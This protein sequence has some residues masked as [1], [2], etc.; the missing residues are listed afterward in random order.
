[1]KALFVILP[2]LVVAIWSYYLIYIISTI[3][4]IC[5]GKYSTKSKAPRLAATAGGLSHGFR[6]DHL[7]QMMNED[8]MRA[9]NQAHDDAVRMSHIA[10][11]D[12]MHAH[13]MGMHMHETAHFDSMHMHDAGMHMHD[14]GMH[15]HNMF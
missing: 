11:N 4:S 3:V 7:Q 9:H 1:M 14:M 6:S 5:K 13:D 10:H 2:I 15:M 12:A 8:A